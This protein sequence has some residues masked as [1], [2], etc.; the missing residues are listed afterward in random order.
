MIENA[1]I[2][3]SKKSDLLD[4]FVTEA[5]RKG[6][7]ILAMSDFLTVSI[8]KTIAEIEINT[9]WTVYHH[10]E[11][12]I[13]EIAAAIKS[14]FDI[15]KIGILV[16]DRSH[17][18]QEILDGL[19]S[20]IYHVGQSKEVAGNLRPA[21]L[22]SNEQLV[23]FF[24]L[25]KAIDPTAV[26]SDISSLTMQ[27]S[28]HRISKQIEEIAQAVQGIINSMRCENLSNRFI[29][30]RD[31]IMQ[32]ALA[33]EED[34]D[35]LLKEADTY[36]L[37][38]LGALYTDTNNQVKSLAARTGP[39]ANIKAIDTALSY[40]N[41]DMK[42][43]PKYVGMRAYLFNY[44]GQTANLMRIL[45]DYKDFLQTLAERKIDG[46]YT[47][48]E[49]IHRNYPYKKTNMDFW[50]ESPMQMIKAIDSYEILLEQKDKDIFYIDAEDHNE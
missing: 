50:L 14:G 1:K 26:L 20:G 24:T 5:D 18:S 12:F 49:T 40:I 37:E 23:K 34:C 11:G 10:V 41:E 9:T 13:G 29:Y 36:L 45:G 47:A 16:A 6:T 3:E 28:L 7:D 38:G 30:A 48:L 33:S 17:F 43:I 27:S 42:M 46:K 31:K 35:T 8:D 19:K 4:I 39:F 21:I 15:S 22:D 25:K 32:A 44:R 2:I